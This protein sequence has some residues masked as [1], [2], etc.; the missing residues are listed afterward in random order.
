M[1]I[2]FSQ[3]R[4][5]RHQQSDVV[6]PGTVQAA[7]ANC[8]RED[9]R[10]SCKGR[11]T[12]LSASVLSYDKAGNLTVDD[13]NQRTTDVVCSR[14]WRGWEVS[15][16]GSEITGVVEIIDPPAPPGCVAACKL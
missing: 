2:D 9:C 5:V 1:A 6:H 10:I 13:G 4:I 12:T 14:C 7:T 16:T 15:Q 3:Y 11:M 8:S